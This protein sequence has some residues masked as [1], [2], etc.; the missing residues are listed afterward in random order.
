MHKLGGGAAIAGMLALGACSDRSA[1]PEHV[2]AAALALEPRLGREPLLGPPEAGWR[3]PPAGDFNQDGLQDVLWRD[4]TANEITVALMNGTRLLEMGPSLPGPPGADWVV[5]NGD[6]DFNLDGMADVLWYDPPTNRIEVWLMQGTVPLE[7]GA[8]IQ[9]PPGDGWTCVPAAD[10]NLDGMADVLWYNPTTNRMSVWLMAG[11]EPFLRGPEIPGPGGGWLAD[12]AADFDRDGMADVFWVDRTEHRMAVWLMDGT[13]VREPGPSLPGQPG[14]GW[15][16]AA[17]GDFNADRVADALW[18]DPRTRRSRIS[19]M[20]GNGLLEQ[21]AD[22]P[23]P[24]GGD[25]IV[26]DASD[27]NGDGMWDMLWLN[28]SP[29]EM[30]VWLMDGTAPFERGESIAGPR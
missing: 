7:Q 29:L 6:G 1:P 21:G 23:G 30:R 4:H 2:A 19:L 9:G 12:F 11:T 13:E 5:V 17:A 25:W 14:D 8:A 24:S 3:L 27:C 28:T 10:F 15:I 20:W 22:I 18:F 26:G 16:L